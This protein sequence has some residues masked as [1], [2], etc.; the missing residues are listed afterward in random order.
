MTER[1]S[2]KSKERE[3]ERTRERERGGGR[4]IHFAFLCG[5]I[6]SMKP[7]QVLPYSK[8]L[9]V[10]VRSTYTVVVIFADVFIHS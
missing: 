8:S 7:Q 3:R 9:A 4:K 1:E 10:R 2:K 5:L 6:E